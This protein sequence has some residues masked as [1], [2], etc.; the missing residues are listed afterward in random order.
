MIFLLWYRYMKNIGVKIA[1]FI[2]AG[3]IIATPFGVLAQDN[4]IGKIN[5]D[6]S[7]VGEIN[8]NTGQITTA[9][10]LVTIITT[11]VNWFAWFIALASVVMGLYAG[12]LFI[13]ARGEPAQ[14]K[15]ARGTLL[16]AIIGIAVAVVSFSIIILT[17]TFFGL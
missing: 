12:F 16:W 14:I 1:L 2:L 4:P 8:M 15:T 10:D 9:N 5:T 17:K 3:N 11:L 7:L 6:G 13:T